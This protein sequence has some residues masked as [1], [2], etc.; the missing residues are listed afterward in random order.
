MTAD[1]AVYCPADGAPAAQL[2]NV[3]ADAQRL[4]D[5]VDDAAVC[6]MELAGNRLCIRGT[7]FRC[8][9]VPGARHMPLETFRKLCQFAAAGGLLVFVEPVPT[10]GLT[11]EETE[12][13]AATWP[14]LL[15]AKHVVRVLRPEDCLAALDL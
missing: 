7:P 3:L 10:S 15:D 1:I 9:I 6:E 12:A 8:V 5:L 13:I 2:C 4:A 14:G 11:P